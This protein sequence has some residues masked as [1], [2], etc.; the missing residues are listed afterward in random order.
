MAN[1]QVMIVKFQKQWEMCELKEKDIWLIW[2]YYTF[3][4]EIA[5]LQI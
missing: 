2:R 1:L 5:Q 3:N 4:R